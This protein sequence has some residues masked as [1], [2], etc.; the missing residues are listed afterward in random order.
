M[1]D[2]RTLRVSATGDSMIARK[3]SLLPDTEEIAGII[4]K[5]DV[6]F[7][8]CECLFHNGDYCPMPRG[9]SAGTLWYAEPELAKELI[10][11]GFNLVSIAN[12]HAS[13]FGSAGLLST[14]HTLEENGMVTAGGGRDLDEARES[15]YL[16]TPSG[17]VALISACYDTWHTQ[18]ERAA[19]AGSG[20][21]S[22]PGMNLLRVKIEHEIS[23]EKLQALSD[24]IREAGLD[25]PSGHKAS[26][27][28][29]L[30]FLGRKF[31][32]GEKPGTRMTVNGD[33]L[34]S[35]KRSIADAKEFADW[36]L[37][38]FH[39]HTSSPRGLEYPSDLIRD[40]AHVSIDNGADAFLGHG[41]H[42]L[43][44]IEI[45]KNRPIFYSLGNFI[46]HNNIV[47]KVTRDQ[48]DFYDLGP[49]SLPSD[50][51]RARFG[52][53]PPSEP[54]YSE[55]WYESVIG[56][57]E[58]TDDGLAGLN[59]QPISLKASGSYAKPETGNP[60]LAKERD[61]IQILANITRLSADFGTRFE[62]SDGGGKLVF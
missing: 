46:A 40:L 27:D 20:F 43:R 42:V 39:S 56:N 17:R 2:P 28:D 29:A 38:S 3:I 22:R 32:A 49:D 14:I 21:P 12:T 7:T 31:K 55:W 52:V 59:I 24:I 10:S 5:S 23:F 13:D 4:G 35:F 48:Y 51:Y 26:D 30:N 58:L 45:Y 47:R 37:V 18:W 57:F 6:R 60:K 33:D 16:D 36:I 1:V 54:P 11:I 15:K 8:N 41:P 19:N 61:G 62:V 50:F 53:I 9:A 25:P 34:G 44:G